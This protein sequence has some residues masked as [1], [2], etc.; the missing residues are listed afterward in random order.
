MDRR[1][2]P[3]G[4]AGGSTTEEEP[5]GALEQEKEE[6]KSEA[7]DTKKPQQ[8]RLLVRTVGSRAGGERVVRDVYLLPGCLRLKAHFSAFFTL[9]RRRRK[10]RKPPQ[11][12][13]WPEGRQACD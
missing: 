7:V 13:G 3:D 8:R 5:E 6:L 4:D 1:P 12:N 2:P 9:S 11:K 10:S